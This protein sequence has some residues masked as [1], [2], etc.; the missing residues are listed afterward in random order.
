MKDIIFQLKGHGEAGMLGEPAQ[1]HVIALQ[2]I[3]EQETSLQAQCHAQETQ[4]KLQL[5]A[6]VRILFSIHACTG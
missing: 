2:L 4:Q 1:E 3:A 6:K 5:A